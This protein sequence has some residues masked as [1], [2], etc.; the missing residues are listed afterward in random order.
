MPNAGIDSATSGGRGHGF[1]NRTSHKEAEE[2]RKALEK[3]LAE[4]EGFESAGS[5]GEEEEEAEKG[6]R[7]NAPALLPCR[8]PRNALTT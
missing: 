2:A 3:R 6:G 4:L 1:R 8:L 7:E 5:E